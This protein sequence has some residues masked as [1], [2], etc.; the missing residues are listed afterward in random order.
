MHQHSYCEKGVPNEQSFWFLQEVLDK[1]AVV[2]A[3]LNAVLY[4]FQPSAATADVDYQALC[5][6]LFQQSDSHILLDVFFDAVALITD[7]VS[8]GI[9][10]ASV[11]SR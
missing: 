10:I 4:A 5:V 9:Q 8:T 7:M 11:F 1:A 6:S 3:A 2:P